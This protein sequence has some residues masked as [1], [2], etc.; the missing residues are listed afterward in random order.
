MLT[1][2]Q[3]WFF[4]REVAEEWHHNQAVLV[5]LR[6]GVQWEA[7][8]A[9]VAAAMKQHDALRLRFRRAE[10]RVGARGGGRGRGLRGV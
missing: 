7:V 6:A 4:A 1:P 5:E 2:V 3:R 9:A 8:A 10:Q